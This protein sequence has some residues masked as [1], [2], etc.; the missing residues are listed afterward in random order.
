MLAGEILLA[1]PERLGIETGLHRIRR[2]LASSSERQS[3]RQ[4]TRQ[5]MIEP[6]WKRA[7]FIR[8]QRHSPL[9]EREEASSLPR[10]RRLRPRLLHSRH[11]WARRR[12]AG[13]RPQA[14]R[15]QWP[16]LSARSAGCAGLRMARLAR[17][18]VHALQGLVE[19]R[20]RSQD[21]SAAVP[22]LGIARIERQRPVQHLQ[23]GIGG[24]FR[25]KIGMVGQRQRAARIVRHDLLQHRAGFFAAACWATAT[26][27]HVQGIA[28]ARRRTPTPAGTA[29]RAP[30][31]SP[32]P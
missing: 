27:E 18:P 11:P 22:A 16:R 2:F 7:A 19:A 26:A 21:Q 29:V 32:R 31:G 9:E 1:G 10:L 6:I 14:P 17:A 13:H 4:I 28:M 24:Q 12:A 20:Q 25:R 8:D 15:C 3:A 30:A 23:R 5:K